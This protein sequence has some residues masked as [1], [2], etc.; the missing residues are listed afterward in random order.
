MAASAQRAAALSASSSATFTAKTAAAAAAAGFSPLPSPPAGLEIEC[1][2]CLGD[3]YGWLVHDSASGHTA[4]IDSPEAGPLIAACDAKGWDL[5]HV[6]I[7]HHHADHCGGNPGLKQRFPGCTIYGPSAEELQIVKTCGLGLD[8]GLAGGAKFEWGG[9]SVDV[10]DVGGHTL[11]HIAYHWRPLGPAPEGSGPP[12][13][14]FVGDSLFVLGC[15]R[16]FE[17]TADQAHASLNRLMALPDETVVY[18]AHEYSEAN[19][20]FAETIE[21]PGTNAALDAR[22]AD[23]RKRRANSSGGP[24]PTVPTTIGMERSTNPFVRPAAVRAALLPKS[25]LT[26]ASTDA[27]AFAEVRRRK[28]K[29]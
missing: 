13:A 25:G 1:V 29:F 5:T 10:I 21:E 19:A 27:E 23:I 14:A 8:E 4:S 22:V 28:D 6:F 12:G 15:G 11:G 20:A 17:G 16:L 18:C 7:T 2:P 3:N 26:E 24:L 9:G